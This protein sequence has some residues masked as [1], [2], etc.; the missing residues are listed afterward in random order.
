MSI[1]LWRGSLLPLGGEAVVLPRTRCFR[2]I[3]TTGIGTAAQSSGS[4]LPRHTEGDICKFSEIS[5]S[6][7]R[8]NS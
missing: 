3:A 6:H 2:Q 7:R 8:P 5:Y 4:K 1:P